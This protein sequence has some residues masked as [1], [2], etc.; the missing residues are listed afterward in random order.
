[1]NAAENKKLVELA[2]MSAVQNGVDTANGNP[3]SPVF[4]EVAQM[5]LLMI[6]DEQ[7]LDLSVDE[8]ATEIVTK[9]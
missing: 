1:M 5:T 4:Y 8:Y 7:G 3:D 6:A 9:W 2:V